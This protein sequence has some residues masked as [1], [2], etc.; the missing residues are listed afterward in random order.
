MNTRNLP[1]LARPLHTH[2]TCDVACPFYLQV[3]IFLFFGP[4]VTSSTPSITILAPSPTMPSL[5]TSILGVISKRCSLSQLTHVTGH[6]F[7]THA[8]P[9][10]M[11]PYTLSRSTTCYCPCPR[12]ALKPLLHHRIPTVDGLF[13]ER[14]LVLT[15]SYQLLR[16]TQHC[17]GKC[18]V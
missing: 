16:S 7:S 17:I 12:Q 6:K 18:R 8:G 13:Q 3:S 14:E 15:G 4:S 5:H 2:V 11:V 10:R 1:N 9:R